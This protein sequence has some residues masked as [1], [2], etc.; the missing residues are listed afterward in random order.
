MRNSRQFTVSRSMNAVTYAG[1]ILACLWLL[2]YALLE[3]P[4]T[5]HFLVVTALLWLTRYAIYLQGLIMKN[6]EQ[7]FS[8]YGMEYCFGGYTISQFGAPVA[9]IVFLFCLGLLTLI[10]QYFSSLHSHAP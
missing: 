5:K 1:A 7:Q 10:I 6:R 2:R 3:S 9:F 8:L 4:Q